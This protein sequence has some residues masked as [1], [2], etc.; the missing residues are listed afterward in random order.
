MARTFGIGREKSCR[1][2][3]FLTEKVCAEVSSELNPRTALVVQVGNE[4]SAYK[5]H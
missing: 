3:K 4:S 2:F 1:T 5:S